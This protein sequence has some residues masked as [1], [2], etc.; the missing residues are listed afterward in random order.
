MMMTSAGH[1]PLDPTHH[2]K[3]LG[4]YGIRKSPIDVEI[5]IMLVV[6]GIIWV[7]GLFSEQKSTRVGGGWDSVCC[8]IGSNSWSSV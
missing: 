8:G 6:I 5:G 4:A 1:S 2:Q 3:K 7:K